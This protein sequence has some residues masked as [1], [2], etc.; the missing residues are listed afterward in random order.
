MVTWLVRYH[1]HLIAKA[2]RTPPVGLYFGVQSVAAPWFLP[3]FGLIAWAVIFAPSDRLRKLVVL[4]VCVPI[5]LGVT[6]AMVTYVM[7]G[8][9]S[10][11]RRQRQVS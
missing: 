2:A 5:F 10:D 3:L 7:A 9:L 6:Y 11:R 8:V 1:R 4:I